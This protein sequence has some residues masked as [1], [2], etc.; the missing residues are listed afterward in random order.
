MVTPNN[1]F[2]ECWN[3]NYKVHLVIMASTV[4]A[5]GWILYN[6]FKNPAKLIA[7]CMYSDSNLYNLNLPWIF[8]KDLSLDK[9]KLFSESWY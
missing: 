9:R 2:L 3:Q 1:F 5:G 7:L 8:K 6:S 4:V